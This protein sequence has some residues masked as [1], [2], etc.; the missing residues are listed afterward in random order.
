MKRGEIWIVSGGSAYTGKARPAVILQDDRFDASRS[1]TVCAFTTN[2][3][4]APLFR[5]PVDPTAA[6]GLQ[7]PCRLMIDKITTIARSRV[8][9]RIGQLE[10]AII[11]RMDR[12]I[13]VYLGLAT[14]YGAARPRTAGANG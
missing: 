12:A 13:I 9:M 4:D 3:T 8:G 14:S 10:P 7:Q 2:L 5:I 11:A 6:N 1:V